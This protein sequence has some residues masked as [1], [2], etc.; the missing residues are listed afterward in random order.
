MIGVDHLGGMV[1]SSTIE[2]FGEAFFFSCQTFTAVGYG[3]INPVGFTASA[4]AAFEALIGLLSFA[5]ATGLLYGRFARPKAYLRFSENAV[6]AP[7]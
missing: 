4:V 1:T 6:L 7:L 5:L 3:R 2:K